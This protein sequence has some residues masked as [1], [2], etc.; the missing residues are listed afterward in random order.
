MYLFKWEMFVYVLAAL[1]VL[2]D[3]CPF[4]SNSLHVCLRMLVFLVD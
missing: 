1:V 2:I 4:D 3:T